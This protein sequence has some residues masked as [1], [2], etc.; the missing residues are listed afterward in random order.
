MIITRSKR[1]ACALAALCAAQTPG[2]V[3]ESNAME[4][5]V[6]IGMREQRQSQGATGLNLSIYDTPQSVSVLS[7]DTLDKF[8]LSDINSTLSL[9]TGVNV[10]AIETDRTYYNARGFDITS[11]HV[12]GVGVPF[13]GLVQGDLDTAIYEKVEII[14]GAN[15]LITGIGNPSGTIN[16]VRKR[17]T[18]ELLLNTKFTVGSWQQKR[19]EA[20]VSVPLSGDSRWAARSVMVVED[21]DSWLDNYHNNRKVFYGIVDGQVGSAVTL[22][23]G[24]T[25][26]TNKSDGVLWGALPLMY[27][28]GTQAEFDVSTST[29]MQWTYWNATTDTAFAELSWQLANDWALRTTYTYTEFDEPS[30]LFYIYLGAQGYDKETGLGIEPYP[31]KYHTTSEQKQWDT[32]IEGGFDAWGQRHQLIVGL[33][34]AKMDGE[35]QDF[36]ALSG[37][38]ALPA[39]PGWRGDEVARPQWD[40]PYLAAQTQVDL[41]RLYGVLRLSISEQLKF[42]VGGNAVRY[43]NSGFSWGVATDSK[44]HGSSPYLGLTWEVIAGLNAYASYSDIYQPQYELGEDFQPLGS[45]K[46]KSYEAGVK[47]NWFDNRLLTSFAVFKTE[48]DNLAEFAGY[49]D[50]DDIDD[51]DY[52]DDFDWALYRGISARSKGF[53]IE[54]AG[55]LSDSVNLQV[56]YTQLQLHDP[57]GEQSR[58]FIP[59]KTL[60]TVLQWQASERLQWGV[61]GRWQSD[62]YY[63]AAAGRIEQPSYF[64][65]GAYG[66]FDFNERLGLSLNIENMS[67]QKYLS[68]LQWEQSYYGKPRAVSVSLHWNI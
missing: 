55:A 47:K 51:E 6:I 16:Y 61:S 12:D 27:S 41:N 36:A 45:A 35:S 58:T 40:E 33:S 23:A 22:A 7:S 65:V 54:A 13:D 9:A 18:N 28:D 14:R 56:G 48:Q 62:I 25:H 43:E 20:D 4:E 32:A 42:L 19:A 60:K 52:S 30:E 38:D 63:Q 8:A 34:L 15:G 11:M 44:E 68:S 10:E 29:T 37:W 5:L 49:S 21:K 1:L 67:D 64:V 3:G 31:G 24:Y 57:E 2:A 26:H 17:P 53:E 39:F 50:G 59:R 46:G 66:A